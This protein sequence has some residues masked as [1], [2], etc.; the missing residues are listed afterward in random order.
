MIEFSYCFCNLKHSIRK[1]RLPMVNM[2][3]DTKISNLIHSMINSLKSQ[4]SFIVLRNIFYKSIV[5]LDKNKCF[6]FIQ[7][8]IG[9]FS[10]SLKFKT[11]RSELLIEVEGPPS[12]LTAFWISSLRSSSATSSRVRLFLKTTIRL[13]VHFWAT[14]V[15]GWGVFRW[16]I[17][18]AR[19]LFFF[20][21]LMSRGHALKTK[22]PVIIASPLATKNWT[23]P[24]FSSKMSVSPRL[25]SEF[26]IFL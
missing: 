21:H 13:F 8:S 16:E 3:N 4:I 9:S 23:L 14:R 19:S 20:H 15:L 7:K 26:S 17:D 11:L 12:R 22:A 5:F 1:G 24:C 10:C 6:Y 18:W 2:R 25:G